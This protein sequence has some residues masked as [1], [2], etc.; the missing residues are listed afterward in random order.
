MD[1]AMGPKNTLVCTFLCFWLGREQCRGAQPKSA[2]A[3][4]TPL[5]LSKITLNLAIQN[6]FYL[7]NLYKDMRKML[8]QLDLLV[9]YAYSAI[10]VYF[11]NI[12][13]KGW[14]LSIKATTN[15]MTHL[16]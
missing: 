10:N 3:G 2:N 7:D 9:I 14:S 8:L 5:P 6:T 11:F 1:S 16:K 13:F 4:N 12:N 15:N